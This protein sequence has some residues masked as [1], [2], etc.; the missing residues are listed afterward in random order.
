MYSSYPSFFLWSNVCSKTKNYCI[1]P[2]LYAM[3][4]AAAGLGGVTRMTGMFL[5]IF[6]ILIPFYLNI[7][8]K[9]V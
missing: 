5:T 2:G 6:L 8:V 3:T 9:F 4:G 1:L 7:F